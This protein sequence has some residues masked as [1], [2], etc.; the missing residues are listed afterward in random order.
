MDTLTMMPTRHKLDVDKYFRMAEAGVFA[1][2]ER[3]ELI[4]GDLFDMAP[5]GPD[6]GAYMIGLNEVFVLACAG[7]FFVSPQN[8]IR[9]SQ[10][11]APEPDLAVLLRRDD[12]YR[13]GGRPGPADV[14]LLVEISD[15]S[16]RFDRTVKLPLYAK[17]G[18]AELWIVDVQRNL[19]EVHTKPTGSTYATMTSFKPGERIALTL[20]PDISVTLDSIFAA[21]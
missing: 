9:L 1:K 5:I 16:L 12:R 15:S 10:F 2:E 3:I 17:A 4:E 18:I 7:R 14:V 20:A 13:M 11:T 19:I 6:H 8:S 21:L